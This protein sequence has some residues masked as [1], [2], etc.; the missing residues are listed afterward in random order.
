MAACLLYS[1]G[2]IASKKGIRTENKS[3]MSWIARVPS[4]WGTFTHKGE[5]DQ[6]RRREA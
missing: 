2:F 3:L 5:R 6:E 4:S 1:D